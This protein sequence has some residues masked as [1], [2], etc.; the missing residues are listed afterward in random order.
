MRDE[1]EFWTWW[2]AG[3]SQVSVPMRAYKWPLE[4]VTLKGVAEAMP[5]SLINRTPPI[6]GCRS[7]SWNQPEALEESFVRVEE[8]WKNFLPSISIDFSSWGK[9]WST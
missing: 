5:D 3:V 6:L 2:C 9:G 8:H 1:T 7:R 4:S